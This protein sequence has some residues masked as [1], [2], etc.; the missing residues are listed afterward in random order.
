[1]PLNTRPRT[2]VLRSVARLLSEIGRAALVRR[3]RKSFILVIAG[4]ARRPRKVLTLPSIL[5]AIQVRAS[6]RTLVYPVYV[7]RFGL[8]PEM[9]AIVARYVGDGVAGRR[10]AVA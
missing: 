4:V 5:N 6:A 8:V 3:R 9:A 1:M 7:V 10:P 2:P